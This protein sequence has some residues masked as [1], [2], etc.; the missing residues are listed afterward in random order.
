MTDIRIDSDKAERIL[1]LLL[2]EECKILPAD[3]NTMASKMIDRLRHA[4]LA[5][6]RPGL[7]DARIILMHPAQE[8]SAK[9]GEAVRDLRSA[10]K[11]GDHLLD[12]LGDELLGGRVWS[13]VW[14]HGMPVP[15]V[16]VT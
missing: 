13:L 10:E 1:A 11:M 4:R 6:T 5:A 9:L 14:E 7:R 12:Q 3:A 16:V 2:R 8:V 15:E